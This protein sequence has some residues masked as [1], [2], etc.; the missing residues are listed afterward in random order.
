[1]A[2]V[3]SWAPCGCGAARRR[4]EGAIEV[5]NDGERDGHATRSGTCR[6]RACRRM[7]SDSPC[8]TSSCWAARA[9]ARCGS[10]SRGRGG[11]DLEAITAV[12]HAVSPIVDE[13][14]CRRRLVPPRGQQ[15]GRRAALRRPE[16]F[17]GAVGEEVS[18][19]FHTEA[20]PPARA[21]RTRRVRRR[22]AV[23][24]RIGRPC[25]R[26]IPSPMSPRRAPSSSGARS[27]VPEGRQDRRGRQAPS[28]RRRNR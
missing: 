20:G 28:A 10:R 14:D 3:F 5:R 26:E 24:S 7:R 27:R 12:T 8:T 21:R 13:A 16:H 2:H 23:P 11:V 9:R 4:G 18:V 25:D 15:P 19:K 6:S 17:T 1:M 22:A